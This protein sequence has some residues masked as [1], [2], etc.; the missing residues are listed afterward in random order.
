MFTEG[1]VEEVKKFFYMKVEKELSANKII[2]I[3]EIRDYIEGKT[4]L[5]KT[6]ELI[7]LKTRQYIKRQFTWARGHMRSW[8]MIYSPNFNDLFKKAIDKIS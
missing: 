2:G 4:T 5:I 1:A 8:D 6:K 7:K 3:N